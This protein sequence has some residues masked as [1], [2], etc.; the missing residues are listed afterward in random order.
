MDSIIS[1]VLLVAKVSEIITLALDIGGSSIKAMLLDGEGNP[2]TDR[3]KQETPRPALPTAVLQ[4]IS[5]LT[6]EWSF[7]RASLGFPGV[8]RQGITRGAINLDRSW[9]GFPLQQILQDSLGVPV[10]IANDA[11]VQGWGAIHGKGLEL[12]ITL[13][14]GFGSSLFIHGQLVPNLE[15]GQHPWRGNR[16]YEQQLGQAALIRVGIKVWNR[17]LQKAIES[18]E[19]AFNYDHLYIGGGNAKKINLPLPQ[20]VTT[21]SNDKG[22]LGGI[23]LWL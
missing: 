1:V 20:N 11:D 23:K 7:Q 15:L 12:V 17:R 2:L 10:R 8:V 5:D 22:L 18:L 14:T 19:T 13:G 4:V 9:D 16:T 21:V 3:R 6:S